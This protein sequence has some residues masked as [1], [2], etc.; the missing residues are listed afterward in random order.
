[1]KDRDGME[2][3]IVHAKEAVDTA[4]N[5]CSRV[6]QAMLTKGPVT[7]LAPLL[8]EAKA[9]LECVSLAKN[10][11]QMMEKSPDLLEVCVW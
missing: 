9:S 8:K 6:A 11:Q 7:K 10:L 5:Q 3:G 1:M 4:S 2:R